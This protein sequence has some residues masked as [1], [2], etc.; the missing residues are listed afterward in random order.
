MKIRRLA[1][2]AMVLL[3]Q[4]CFSYKNVELQQNALET[5]SRYKLKQFGNS[6]FYKGELSAVKDSLLILKMGRVKFKEIKLDD[7]QEVKKGTFSLGNT[8]ALPV[9]LTGAIFGA[10]WIYSNNT[11]IVDLEFSSSNEN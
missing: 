7:I 8:I 4:S 11:S 6:R 1:I 2:I 10:L 5:G 9:V 3:L